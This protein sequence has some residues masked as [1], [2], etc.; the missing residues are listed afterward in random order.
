MSDAIK[1][2]NLKKSYGTHLVLDGLNF[3]VRQGEI[4]RCL[5][6]MARVKRQRWNV[7]RDCEHMMTEILRSMGR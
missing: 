5:A 1:I 4:L 6:S 2:S 7:S 3:C